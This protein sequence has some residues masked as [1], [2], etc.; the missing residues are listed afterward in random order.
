MRIVQKKTANFRISRRPLSHL[1]PIFWPRRNFVL[2]G[3]LSPT[4]QSRPDSFSYYLKKKP[5]Y[6][7]RTWG[8]VGFSTES[9]LC[10]HPLFLIDET[11]C[12]TAADRPGPTSPQD[13]RR[14]E[15]NGYSNYVCPEAALS[16]VRVHYVAHFQRIPLSGGTSSLTSY[17]VYSSL[18]LPVRVSN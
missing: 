12:E 17:S 6:G 9:M 2:S 14:C 18:Y 4:L 10:V 5:K 11:E 7:Q 8:S 1:R 15:K 16:R 13:C 3:L